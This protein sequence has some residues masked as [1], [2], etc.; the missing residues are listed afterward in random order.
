MSLNQRM[1]TEN[2][3]HLHNGILF[4]YLKQ[5][6]QNFVSKWMELEN[7]IL[8]E[9]IQTLKD[10]NGVYTLTVDFSQKYRIPMIHSTEPKKVNKKEDPSE[11]ASI[12]LK[13]GNKIIT[14]GRGRE[15]QG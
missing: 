14:G 9:V 6:H 11:D 2:V 12:P 10:M 5:G 1:D 15:G 3:V 13:M 7:I 4:S 8:S